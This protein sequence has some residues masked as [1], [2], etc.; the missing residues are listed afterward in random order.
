[1]TDSQD[2]Q[3]SI[4]AILASSRARVQ[5]VLTRR[6]GMQAGAKRTLELQD[7]EERV[8]YSATPV[9][10]PVDAEMAACVACEAPADMQD[11]ASHQAT[12]SVELVI[13]D[14]SV[15]DYEQLIDGL[16][17]N[18]E[19]QFEILIL[20]SQRDG[21]E[22]ITEMLASRDDIGALHIVS[23]G[24]DGAVQLGSTTLTADN[25]GLY[26]GM[27][28]QWGDSLT[29]DADILFYGCDLGASDA[30]REF[31]DSLAI[32]T[33]ADVAASDDLTGHEDLGGDWE[34]EINTGEIESSLAFTQIV[35]A[36]WFSTLVAPE[37][38]FTNGETIHTN[39]SLEL[40]ASDL[41]F[42]IDTNVGNADVRVRL[43]VDHGSLTLTDQTGLTLVGGDWFA[44]SSVTVEGSESNA[45]NAVQSIVYTPDENW[46]G[47][48]TVTVSVD[49]LQGG[50][51]SD[52]FAIGVLQPLT[53]G[54]DTIA[55]SGDTEAN[56][57]LRRGVTRSISTGLD[58]TSVIAW[59]N[60]ATGESHWRTLGADGQLGPVE[61]LPG[62]NSRYASVAID[63]SDPNGSFI[64]TWTVSANDADADIRV[65]R[66]GF[67]G[68]TTGPIVDVTS[69]G[70]AEQN[71]SIASN[72]AGDYV[73]VWESPTGAQFQRFDKN[74]HRID[75]APVN[76][77]DSVGAENPAIGIDADRNVL[78]SWDDSGGAY[79]TRFSGGAF[80]P[81][82]TLSNATDAGGS[83][84]AVNEAGQGVITWHEQGVGTSWDVH[85]LQ[86]NGDGTLKGPRF[87]VAT[88][89]GGVE[90]NPSV[91]ISEAGDFAIAWEADVRLEVINYDWD[92]NTA[93]EVRVDSGFPFNENA[94]VSLLDGN[95]FVV[96]YSETVAGQ[97]DVLARRFSAPVTDTADPTIFTQDPLTAMPGQTITTEILLV[98]S[99]TNANDLTATY[100]PSGDITS[101]TEGASSGALRTVSLD[102]AAS[103]TAGTTSTFTVEVVDNDGDSVSHIV[104]VDIV[105][106]P[107][108]EVTT[109][110]DE[111]DGDTSSIAALIA[112][113]GGTGISLREAITAA[114]NTPN[115]GSPDEITFNIAGAGPQVIELNLGGLPGISDAITIDGT[116]QG[117]WVTIDGA[118]GFFSGLSFE[119]GSDGSEVTGLIVRDFGFAGITL[120]SGSSDIE[121]Y[122]NLL[123]S[124]A[125]DGSVIIG[126]GNEGGIYILG[127]D[128]IVG[129]ATASERNV[130]S[131]NRVYGVQFDA[132]ASGNEVIG[133]YIGTDR[134]GLIDHGNVVDGVR[135]LSESNNNVIDS[136]VISGNDQTGITFFQNARE[137]Q[138][139]SNL[140][141]V[142]ADGV[143]D[144]GNSTQGIWFLDSARDN[145][146]G[147]TAADANTIANNLS[148]GISVVGNA[149]GN[150]LRFNEIFD[151]G[152]LGID[153]LGD[154]G[155]A[156]ND[157]LDGDTGPNEL[158]NYPVLQAAV[159]S[160]TDLAITG[161]INSTPSTI[162]LIDFYASAT[163]DPTGHGEAERHI[164]SISRTTDLSGEINFTSMLSGVG[165]SLGEVITATAT[166]LNGNTSEFS[167]NVQ[168]SSG[169][170]NAA[171]INISSGFVRTEVDE[172]LLLASS[173]ANHLR[174]ADADAGLGSLRVSLEV[175]RG[176]LTLAQTDGISFATGDGFQ[177]STIVM[178]GTLA[179]LNAALDGLVYEPEPGFT[180]VVD[181][182]VD[183]SDEGNSG[184]GGP[185]TDF[186]IVQISVGTEVPTVDA[187]VVNETTAGDQSTSSE[188]TGSNA[189]TFLPDGSYVVVWTDS[190]NDADGSRGVYARILNADGSE[191]VSEFQVSSDPTGNEEWANVASDA[192]GRF[193]VVWTQPDADGNGVFMRRF[194]A[195]G[196]PLDVNDVQV[197]TH[198]T[199]RQEDA[200]VAVNRDGRGVIVWEGAGATDA[201]GIYAR[202]FTIDGGFD[203]LQELRVNENNVG[204]E[205]NGQVAINDSG[206][207]VVVYEA[208]GI[209]V[210][211]F[212][213]SNNP[214]TDTLVTAAPGSEFPTVAINNDGSFVVAYG[215]DDSIDYVTYSA[216]GVQGQ[217]GTVIDGND[218]GDVA[219]AGDGTGH[220]VLVYEAESSVKRVGLFADGTVAQATTQSATIHQGG[221]SLPSVDIRDRFNMVFVWTAD[222]GD[223]SGSAVMA[224]TTGILQREGLWL[225]TEGVGAGA[226]ATFNDGS[227]IAFEGD[228]VDLG[229]TTAGT[230]DVVATLND[231]F[232]PGAPGLNGLHVVERDIVV[233]PDSAPTQLRQG[234]WILSIDNAVF[235]GG[236]LFE[237]EDLLLLRRVQ[238][239]NAGTLSVLF[240]G[241]QR[242]E[243][244][245]LV[246][247]DTLIGDTVVRA[248]DLLFVQSGGGVE[249]DIW[250]APITTGGASQLL[251]RGSDIGVD[252]Q[253]TALD[254][255]EQSTVV[256][257]EAL[258]V[259]SI[260]LSTQGPV[261]LG[262]NSRFAADEDVA[263][264][265]VTATTLGSGTTVATAGT[266]FDG[267]D[268]DLNDGNGESIDAVAVLAGAVV[269][270][271]PE[272]TAALPS[273]GTTDENTPSSP[274]TVH[275]ILA[276]TATDINR[277]WPGIA[278][279]GLTGNGQWQYSIDGGALWVPITGVSPTSALLLGPTA[280]IRYVPDM[281]NGET[282]QLT[283][284]AWDQTSGIQ[285]AT[286]D[287]SV[288]GGTTAFS[289]V[290]DTAT[291]TVTEVNDPGTV[292]LTS[293]INNLSETT[294]LASNLHVANVAIDDD[295]VGTNELS[296]TGPDA[297]DFTIIGGGL[298]LKAGTTL[299]FDLQPIFN[300]TVELDDIGV[301][302][303]PDSTATFVLNIDDVNTAPT[304]DTDEE[305]ISLAEN[306]PISTDR[307]VADLSVM[308]DVAGTNILGLTGPDA[309]SFVISG[310]GLYLRAGTTLDFEDQ[311]SYSVTVTV[312]DPTL[313]AGIEDSVD[314]I[315]SITDVDEAPTLSLENVV[316]NIDENSDTSASTRIADILVMDDALGGN[317]VS[318]AGADATDFV[319]VGTELHLR[320]GVTLDFESKS[321]FDV[322]VVV[323]D[324][325][326]GSEIEAPHTLFVNDL[327]EAPTLVLTAIHPSLAEDTSTASDIPIADIAVDD[328]ALGT[329]NIT[330]TGAD[331]GLF[332]V[333]AGQLV[334]R[335]G[336]AL[337]F[338][339]RSSYSVTVTVDDPTLGAGID[340]SVDY[341]LSI[342]DVD[343]APTLSLENVVNNIDENS[344]TSASIRIADVLVMDDA[345]GGNTVSLAGADAADFV[346][347]GTE[348]H[349]RAGVTLDFESK[350]RFDVTV[351]VTDTTTGS[352]IEAPHTLFVNDLNEAPTLNLTAIQTSLAEDTS[353]AS[354]IPIA[355]IAVD[356]DALGTNNITLTGAD[357]GLF[358]VVADQLVLR[359][360]TALDFEDQQSYD[361]SVVLDD[362]TLGTGDEAVV[363]YPFS[364]TDVNDVRPIVDP[365][366]NFSVVESAGVGDSVGFVQG[367]DPDT[368]GTL[369]NWTIAS[370]D[371]DGIFQINSGTGEITIADDS[372]LDFER[373][374]SYTLEITV[375]DEVQT[376]LRQDIVINI[377]DVN[378]NAPVLSAGQSFT[379]AENIANDAIVGQLMATD[380]DANTTLTWSLTDNAG[381][382][383]SINPNSGQLMVANTNLLDFEDMTTHTVTVVASDGLNSSTPETVTINLTDVNDN[384]PVIDSGQVFVIS[385]AS[386]VGLVVGQ[387]TADDVDT[388]TVLSNWSIV[389]GSST[390]A[391]DSG[392]GI[393][394]VLDPTGLDFETAPSQTLT[395]TVSDGT[396]TSVPT[397]VTINLT[398]VNDVA[399]TIVLPVPALTVDEN[400]PPGTLVGTLVPSDPDTVGFAQ[401]WRIVGGDPD[402][403]FQIDKKTGEIRVVDPTLLDFEVQSSYTLDIQV[404]D[405]VQDSAPVGIQIDV[406]DV[407]GE[408]TLAGEI[409][410]DIDG[411][412]VLG[413]NN[414]VGGVRVDL[415]RDTG[416]GIA[417]A[418]DV[419]VRS[420]FSTDTNGYRFTDLA[421]ATYFVV[422]DSRT[423]TSTTDSAPLGAIWAEQTYGSAGSLLRDSGTTTT[424]GLLYGGRYANRSDDASALDTAE[425]V[426]RVDLTENETGV[427]FGFSFNVV[428]NTLG[429]D[430]QD[431][432]LSSDRS[433]QGS[434]RQFITN[435]NAID[436]GNRL[437]F[438]P[439]EGPNDRD[440]ANEWWRLTVT[441][442]LPTITGAGTVID[443][444]AWSATDATQILN[445]N[446]QILGRQQAVGLGVDGI[447]GTADDV[448]LSG[449]DAP[450]LE[451]VN[452]RSVNVVSVGLNVQA[453]DVVVQSLAV[454]GFGLSTEEDSGNIKIGTDATTN[455]VG[456]QIRDNVIGSSA[457]EF[458][459]PEFRNQGSNIVIQG[460]DGGI[461]EN[462]LIGYSDAWGIKVD[463]DA[464]RWTFQNNEFVQSSVKAAAHDAIDLLR[465]SG[466]AIVVGNF[467]RNTGGIAIDSFQSDGGNLISDNTILRSG[468]LN[469][470]VAGVRLFGTGNIV[471]QN[472]ID[473]NFAADGTGGAGIIVVGDTPDFGASHG[474]RISRNY[475][476]DNQGPSIDL[477]SGGLTTLE[478]RRGDGLTSTVGFDPLSGNEG[479]DAPL[480][481]AATSVGGI[482]TVTG[483][484]VPNSTVEIYTAVRA[485]GGQ[486]YLGQATTNGGGEFTFAFAVKSGVTAVTAN[487]TDPA[488]NTS[489][490]GDILTV[491]AAPEITTPSAVSVDENRTTVTQLTGRDV[492]TASADLTWR[493]TGGADAGT[494]TV[495]RSGRLEFISPQ[496]FETGQNLFEVE[497]TI[498]DAVGATDVRTLQVEVTPVNDNAP[499]FTTPATVRVSESQAAVIDVDATDSDAP[500][501]TVSYRIVGGADAAE[502]DIDPAT[503]ELEFRGPR[504]FESPADVGQDNVYEVQ[505]EAN[506]GSGSTTLQD[507]VV[508]VTDENDNAPDVARQSMSIP[509]DSLNGTVVG[510]V[511]ASDVDTVGGPLQY[512]LADDL[513]GL[514][515]IDSAS[516]QITLADNSSVDHETTPAYTL[517]VVVS[518]GTNTASETVDI[519]ITN[520][521]ESPTGLTLDNATIAENSAGAVIG[522][523]RF[524]DVDAADT[525]TITV[526][527]DTRF[528]VVS[529]ELKLRAGESLDHENDADPEPV[530]TVTV[531]DANGL[532]TS[533]VFEITVTDV[534]EAPGPISLEGS[535]V[536][537]HV[538]GAVVGALTVEDSDLGDTHRFTVE[539]GSPFEVVNG[540]LRLQPN[541]SLDFESNPTV[542]VSV[543]ATDTGGNSVTQEFVITVED[544]QLQSTDQSVAVQEDAP[545]TA[546]DLTAFFS[547][548][549]DSGPM[550]FTLLSAGQEVETVTS[551]LSEFRVE[552]DQLVVDLV[553]DA[554]GSEAITI[555]ATLANGESASA[556]LELQVIAVNDAPQ[557]ETTA[558]ENLRFGVE[559]TDID[560][561]NSELTVV[562][563]VQPTNGTVEFED[564]EFIYQRA[565][566]FTGG[567]DSFAYQVQDSEGAIS[568]VVE[569]ELDVPRLGVPAPTTVG[570]TEPVEVEERPVE[571]DADQSVGDDAPVME[572]TDPGSLPTDD[573]GN[574]DADTKDGIFN[575]LLVESDIDQ[576]DGDSFVPNFIPFQQ[577]AENEDGRRQ[578]SRT[579]LS[580]ENAQETEEDVR[581]TADKASEDIARA[582]RVISKKLKNT[583]E[584][585]VAAISEDL[586]EPQ[587]D[588]IVLNRGAV[589]LGGLSV[590]YIIWLLRGGSL[591]ASMLTSIPAWR[592][593]DPLPI[594]DF[595]DADDDDGDSL[596]AMIDRNQKLVSGEVSAPGQEG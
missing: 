330:L 407:S 404:S 225:S 282:A 286:A 29:A 299:N 116:T 167:L 66:F 536:V 31:V 439:V 358:D 585:S 60:D 539:A 421:D 418:A 223:G 402:G 591:V 584:K 338:E 345:L 248:G 378:D 346:V 473:G 111:S 174:I 67:D 2:R 55:D 350:P 184:S 543:T 241:T 511:R 456:V 430:T 361:V 287:A 479:I 39:T 526:S 472:V 276:G 227:L 28:G 337:D 312:D 510:T 463:G 531:T 550:T 146:I 482:A 80:A 214:G 449:V 235:V 505:V 1:M 83:A 355:D 16:T 50:T 191:K 540:E 79:F 552:G 43:D 323:T 414:L 178:F 529:G 19:D 4:A 51:A 458:A 254:L 105:A 302:G 273:L 233:G 341:T 452:D 360:G 570:P 251:I 45:Q 535:T 504:D 68:S 568:D 474:N 48:A 561:A 464:D 424:D 21:I 166:D 469:S 179:D 349:L 274:M 236:M 14:E 441:H 397:D 489:E 230:L 590:G 42:T 306:T 197:N 49:D 162:L 328:D 389:G 332:D 208:G 331:A 375:D 207:W 41:D 565:A 269:N 447:A 499:A 392:T 159:V 245:T 256:G 365:G 589:S 292:T 448:W 104:A 220:F 129:G 86:V 23:H 109:A 390:F 438:V 78:I 327:N 52:S 148:S 92:G 18:P 77:P 417:N 297:D 183:T 196:S 347:V 11:A 470:E 97:S 222:S 567:S 280:E 226:G 84:I 353:T 571:D 33:G 44:S 189:V 156:A 381:G 158:Q 371:V 93:G 141:G 154:G 171:P 519:A 195:D 521:N 232:G 180:G 123:G 573:T 281:V 446:D 161:S 512:S 520:V 516:G 181:L 36:N 316:N 335:A 523:L 308:D 108:F 396:L 366:Q 138:V 348:L 284:Q 398:D 246:E 99:D 317:T 244:I 508:T 311:S 484:A 73:V 114:N 8:L 298:F 382:R 399:P 62:D 46:T 545:V 442:A 588:Q 315:L 259:G 142:G 188:G 492:E 596:D 376:S 94:S 151:N 334:L 134:T 6:A 450:E 260:V 386:S 429:G 7:L 581:G 144:L 215:R 64:A 131:G 290:S 549:Q 204:N 203:E 564:G 320:A 165:V 440:G 369:W 455:Y 228:P 231:L 38:E 121:V 117:D 82:L 54:T 488:G 373:A 106:P 15:E 547:G 133:N 122:G 81:T 400:A 435:A 415:Y 186:D 413:T 192:Q 112:N 507:I 193:V 580:G 304:V 457:G 135:V 89:P 243:A 12:Q 198:T 185:K 242:A 252:S 502:F 354:D 496:D 433:V 326:T 118:G 483:K 182:L 22:Q 172:P 303:S 128:H 88:N 211:Q 501:Q 65:Q 362:P 113:P 459:R 173:F 500:V 343:E 559:A 416:D 431:D 136:N 428:T 586:A 206:D 541:Q 575:P 333:V 351:V 544:R 102:V 217:S 555:V 401:N 152:A 379:V 467:F 388:A 517:T 509:E 100:S 267:N 592:M 130:L 266:L 363:A 380:E 143:T 566:G 462:N 560:S 485:G 264:L 367:T 221:S 283:Y 307:R 219:I 157:N 576:E 475:F 234:D 61:D 593:V 595:L 153:L 149:R 216:T 325:T 268:V 200:R 344:N 406:V 175:G 465:G 85:A 279:T 247:Q 63:K 569:V 542:A 72:A 423:V 579:D 20:D 296:L 451:I 359:A 490:F 562:N 301:G 213:S 87:N 513:G 140:I 201:D 190:G 340:D 394:T 486:Q 24:R 277:D 91:A 47:T 17:S 294:T 170:A 255:I 212:D 59:R 434:L 426:T 150:S 395:L 478:N 56:R 209:R 436:G 13:V 210:R 262:T 70:V 339:D 224:R 126:E 387:A 553:P 427:T 405:G 385:E 202:T 75:T 443:G 318:L 383:F 554:F 27:L 445:P 110:T 364:I 481:S 163:A 96:L 291:L 177:D 336:T 238:G 503:G 524:D 147:G 527:G 497:V 288:N 370:G 487:V 5:R 329:N 522:T 461:V 578:D 239:A 9:P 432:D 155:H 368:V 352:D 582:S 103:A 453:D 76:V 548:M 412:G 556:S 377:T 391:I 538:A 530:V 90:R 324:T 384:A 374:T 422:V 587:T 342:T 534:N 35:Q 557:V 40:G 558:G 164:G 515:A 169:A 270:S 69:V 125:D 419:L 253:I 356:D 309:A 168:A 498:T 278:V 466:D 258:A 71:S 594:L 289:V 257:G 494:F 3:S 139:T 101:A 37:V 310:D 574:V 476:G 187:F 119:T 176:T 120:A 372:N 583:I 408:L 295:G 532:S 132:T 261:N 263:V 319:V 495:T 199:G 145:V 275:A 528:E 460:A 115:N 32:L 563:V 572:F 272:L 26:A 410:E 74:D 577:V 477:V 357:A 305:L 293:L 137:N 249:Q 403:V 525:H 95:N 514:F 314:Y 10:V 98:D 250:L 533:E 124:F 444:T 30:G 107:V 53:S 411:D 409:Y 322:T 393:I 57:G 425:H 240:D 437:R 237:P 313:G 321:Q 493:I 420:V 468:Q 229:G 285:G 218:L 480:L 537:E 34:L 271:A 546:Y 127:N 551:D 58:G 25:L 160:G 491:N 471:Q 265:T 300:V 454:N 518:D 506:D 205:L 194:D